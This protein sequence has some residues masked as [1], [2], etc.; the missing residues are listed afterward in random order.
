MCSA[1][2]EDRCLRI[3]LHNPDFLNHMKLKK[4]R[5]R[6]KYKDNL[7]KQQTFTMEIN[8]QNFAKNRWETIFLA[9]LHGGVAF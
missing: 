1:C 9:P 2:T 3:T 8:K 5:F 7:A 4:G 6:K